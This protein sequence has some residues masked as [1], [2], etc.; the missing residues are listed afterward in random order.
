MNVT[1]D[2]IVDLLP[3]YFSGE[4][5]EDT[6]RLVED[7]FREDPDFERTARKA[8]TPLETLRKTAPIPPDAEREKRD[9]QWT[10][11]EISRRRLCFGVALLLTFAPLAAMYRNGHL[12][13]PVLGNPW[14]LALVW[15]I[16]AFF[17]L[18]YLFSRLSR[19]TFALVS[20]SFFALLP[21]VFTFHLF[22][23]GWRSGLSNRW[24]F[25]I[26]MWSVAAFLAV[27]YR[28]WTS[29]TRMTP[30]EANRDS[31]ELKGVLFWFLV[32]ALL[33]ALVFLW[34]G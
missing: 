28:A 27:R 13:W 19:R 2:V 1:R 9:L 11:A 33:A 4:A 22:L 26:G 10:R 3:V 20:V 5:S 7:Y 18:F 15:S 21:L 30:S 34:R 32:L 23:P 31:I 6:K 16:A 14:L 24:V 8:A 17:W 25:G 29:N 12:N